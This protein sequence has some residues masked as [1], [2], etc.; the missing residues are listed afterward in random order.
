MLWSKLTGR[1]RVGWQDK[2][3]AEIEAANFC[4][5]T[6]GPSVS[7]RQPFYRSWTGPENPTKRRMPLRLVSIEQTRFL[8]RRS[9]IAD[10]PV[11]ASV[12]QVALAK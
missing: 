1:S 9:P 6:K 7:Y 2:K 5:L 12:Q 11:A 4:C 10:S 8:T 3:S